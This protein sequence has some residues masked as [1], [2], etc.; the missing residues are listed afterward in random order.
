MKFFQEISLIEQI[1]ISSYFIWAKLYAQLHLAF[2]KQKD[3]DDSIA[4]GVSFPDY[5]SYKDKG[6]GGLGQRLRIFANTKEELEALKL[7]QSL[8]RLVD[9]V[10]I[11]P[12]ESVP[13]HVAGYAM[14][15]RSQVKSNPERLARRYAKRHHIH[16]EE[17]LSLYEKMTSAMTNLPFIQMKSL[18]SGQTFKLFIEKSLVQNVTLG[19]TF[20]TYGLSSVSIVP[21]F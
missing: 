18:S 6:Q 9:Y 5:L 3:A 20:T 10:R 16:Y 14:Y 2:V 17:A 19:R 12:I 7:S 21:E 4:Y 13:E 8:E 15:Q 11:N 1:E